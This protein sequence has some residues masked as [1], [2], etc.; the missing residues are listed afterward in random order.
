MLSCISHVKVLAT[1]NMLR[2]NDNKTELML[3]TAKRTMHLHNLPAS[4]TIGNA[5]VHLKQ[6][7]KILGLALDCDFTMNPHVTNIAQT[8]YI[9]L[10]PLASIRRFLTCTATAIA[11]SAFVL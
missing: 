3:I 8:C 1:E 7:V 6:S 11:V 4:I 5:K 9:D 2:L 10:H